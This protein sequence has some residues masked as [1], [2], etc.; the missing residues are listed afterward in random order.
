MDSPV[1][2]ISRPRVPLDYGR[3]RISVRR[4]VGRILAVALLILVAALAFHWRHALIRH[5]HAVHSDYWREKCAM[6]QAPPQ[7]VVFEDD[8]VRAAKMLQLSDFASCAAGFGPAPVRR[9]VQAL[10]R[11][12][13][14]P[15]T[16]PLKPYYVGLLVDR[17]VLFCHE[18]QRPD[19]TKVILVITY[20]QEVLGS[21]RRSYFR[22][23]V[24]DRKDFFDGLVPQSWEQ[25]NFR[26]EST[27][28]T[29]RPVRFFAGERVSG[30][31]SSCAFSYQL[32]DE[33]G[34]YTFTLQ[35]DDVIVRT[36]E[37]PMP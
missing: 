18:L 34:R 6:F 10:E 24:C 26:D 9:R 19:G 3:T 37:G 35:P 8:P 22:V 23:F 30:D 21:Q 15:G 32:G 5:W 20:D 16:S 25:F 11:Y 36:R 4:R 2:P 29:S 31:P 33:W 28:P 17:P 12:L 14:V 13:A 1:E 7:E 27:G